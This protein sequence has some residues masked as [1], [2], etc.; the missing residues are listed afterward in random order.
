MQVPRSVAGFANDRPICW[1]RSSPAQC[2]NFGCIEFINIV[3][4]GNT[5][6]CS[7][8][9]VFLNNNLL[10][11]FKWKLAGNLGIFLDHL[12]KIPLGSRAVYLAF[13]NIWNWYW[14]WLWALVKT[15]LEG[16]LCSSYSSPT[17]AWLVWFLLTMGFQTGFVMD[18]ESQFGF[19][20]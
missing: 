11:K 16:V 9:R 5:F 8:F 18:C 20:S 2:S 14:S 12:W 19:H 13:V 15:C 17:V 7:C 1:I 6:Y 10:W 3:M 4:L